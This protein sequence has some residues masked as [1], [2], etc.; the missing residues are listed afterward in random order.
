MLLNGN[1]L[2]GDFK[3]KILKNWKIAIFIVW[4]LKIFNYVLK[5]KERNVR[6]QTLFQNENWIGIL[7]Q[8][9]SCL[10]P[11]ESSNEI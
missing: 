10:N 4:I 5:R 7:N 2:L 6:V 1:L 11:N 3:N 8:I 9:L